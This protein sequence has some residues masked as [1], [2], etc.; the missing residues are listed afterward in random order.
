ML[1][2]TRLIK[3]TTLKASGSYMHVACPCTGPH[4]PTAR[5]SDCDDSEV[6]VVRVGTDED[7]IKE[8]HDNSEV[9]DRFIV[10]KAASCVKL[11]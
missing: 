5:S 10:R 2:C 9:A 3:T 1:C 8:A 11:H 4:Q 7:R 6:K